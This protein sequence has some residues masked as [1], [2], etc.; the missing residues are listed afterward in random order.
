MNQQQTI[1]KVR[2]PNGEEEISVQELISVNGVPY[3]P[4]LEID[5]QMEEFTRA[6]TEIGTRLYAVEQQTSAITTGLASGRGVE[7]PP[8]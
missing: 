7:S 2:W 5:A 3:I 6:I 8:A 1:L 4:Q